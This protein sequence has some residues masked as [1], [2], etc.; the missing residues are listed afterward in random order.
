MGIPSCVL[1]KPEYEAM[2]GEIGGIVRITPDS[3]KAALTIL[4]M[5]DS[6]RARIGEQGKQY[7]KSTH[8]NAVIASKIERIYNCI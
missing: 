6:F 8:D 4:I 7:V 2:V 1:I 3:L 5:D